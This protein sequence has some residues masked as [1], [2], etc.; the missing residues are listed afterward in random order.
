MLTLLRRRPTYQSDGI[1]EKSG[2]RVCL[3][4]TSLATFPLPPPLHVAASEVSSVTILALPGSAGRCSLH[5]VLGSTL[6]V[7]K[8]AGSVGVGH[9]GS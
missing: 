5:S 1:F 3:L 8:P 9:E 2:K 7:L 6:K 4:Q